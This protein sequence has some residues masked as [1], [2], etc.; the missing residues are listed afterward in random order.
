MA[1]FLVRFGEIGI[2]S[3]PVRRRFTRRLADNVAA[4]LAKEGVDAEVEA[5]WSRVWVEVDG[6]DDAPAVD[7]AADALARTFGV[8]SFSPVH[9]AEADPDKIADRAVDLLADR[10]GGPGSDEARDAI[11]AFAVRARRH[12]DHDFSSQDVG[13]VV[14]AAVEEA[15]GA[16]VDL[17]APDTEVFVEVRGN[18][19][20]V[21]FEKVDGPGG[22][23]VACQGKVALAWG[24]GAALA[25]WLLMKRGVELFPVVREGQEDAVK[26]LSPWTPR[27]QVTVLD[28]AGADDAAQ[29]EGEGTEAG[30]AG[31]SL[32]AGRWLALVDRVAGD[33][34][35]DAVAAGWCLGEG[36][37]TRLKRLSEVCSLPVL[38]PLAGFDAEGRAG[39]AERTGLPDDAEPPGELETP[40]TEPDATA[41]EVEL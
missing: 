27:L 7:A 10:V 35:C 4:M 25:G 28:V 33:R 15:F 14:G 38:T 3:A 9:L 5:S 30:E 37:A 11:G 13:V 22:L 31:T 32:D 16:P 41:R 34:R 26:V 36:F 17:D 23:P 1:L 6:D 24:P 12:G 2:K 19:A 8:V 20:F 18:E 40:F 39:L 21:F 29:A